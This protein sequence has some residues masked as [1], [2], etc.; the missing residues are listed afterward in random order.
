M[1]KIINKKWFTLIELM[2]VISIMSI[3]LIF[4]FAP[5]NLYQSK[6]RVKLATRE[7]A[8]SFY[9]AR[10]M[11]VSWIQEKQDTENKSVWILLDSSEWNNDK[12]KYFYL[13]KEIKDYPSDLWNSFK[14]KELQKW[15]L[16]KNFW[17]SSSPNK[18]L[19]VYKAATWEIILFEDGGK[20]SKEKI[21]IELSY[22][23]STSELL[24]RTITYYLKTNIVDY[25][26]K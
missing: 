7:I 14:E 4:S 8:Q 23:K 3:I 2:I 16:I 5:Y 20:S 6:A 13:D 9:E 26:K 11:A 10:N 21:E 18:I 17:N 22:Q 24:N 15:I 1:K 12:I 25:E 19:V